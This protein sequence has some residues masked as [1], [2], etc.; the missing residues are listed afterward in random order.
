MSPK[1]QIIIDSR[2]CTQGR[3]LIFRIHKRVRTL[4]LFYLYW[5]LELHVNHIPL[6][7]D[8][9]PE[10]CLSHICAVNAVMLV[11]FDRSGDLC[12]GI[13]MRVVQSCFAKVFVLRQRGKCQYKVLL[14]GF[15]AIWELL[16]LFYLHVFCITLK[17]DK[18]M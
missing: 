13:E 18:K 7:W 2:K 17:Y 11:D 6:L 14:V 5:W 1:Y 4:L 16:T 10:E 12:R 15:Q 9:P 8:E 3:E